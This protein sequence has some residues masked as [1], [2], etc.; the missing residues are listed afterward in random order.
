MVEFLPFAKA[1]AEVQGFNPLVVAGEEPDLCYRLRQRGWEIHRI[2]VLMAKHDADMTKFS[3][4]W[5]RSVRSGYGYAL[6]YFLHKGDGG[7]VCVRECTKIW[8]WALL[9][10]GGILFAAVF[11]SGW[12]SLG[13]LGYLF[14]FVKVFFWS[15]KGNMEFRKAFI[16]AF[17]MVIVKWPQF[18]GQLS[19]II[20]KIFNNHP[21]IIEY[22]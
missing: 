4:W 6:G 17:F 9:F 12:W 18:V 11:L 1:F 10:P 20:E 7:K 14:Q 21:E 13:L 2:D 3:Q 8:F 5:K 22:R 16:Y 19:Y 15:R